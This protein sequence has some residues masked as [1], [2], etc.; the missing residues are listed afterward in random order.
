MAPRPPTAAELAGSGQPTRHPKR[1][2]YVAT[3]ANGAAES[4]IVQLNDQVPVAV[5]MPSAWT[6]ADLAFSAS[7]D[8]TNFYPVVDMEGAAVIVDGPPAASMVALPHQ[9]L[10][11]ARFLKLRSIDVSDGTP[12]NQLAERVIIVITLP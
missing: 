11:G 3:I 7:L 4:D 5:I 2:S 8:G 6:T 12:E 1:V 10:L 9:Q